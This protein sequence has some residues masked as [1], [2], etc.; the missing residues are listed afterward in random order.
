MTKKR[1]E[2]SRHKTK[3]EKKRGRTENNKEER[4]SGLPFRTST[5][6]RL[7]SFKQE[8]A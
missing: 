3:D 2:Q 8:I 6:K 4:P 7:L 1:S 5:K